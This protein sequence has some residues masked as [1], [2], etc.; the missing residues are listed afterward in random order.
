MSS[1]PVQTP[2]RGLQVLK[3]ALFFLAGLMLALGLFFS[4]SLITGAHAV[5]GNFLLPFEFLNQAISNLIGPMITSFLINLGVI[6]LALSIVI[7]ALLFAIGLLIGHILAL[8][9]RIARLERG[10]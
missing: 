1:T 9:G 10:E 5:V 3:V 7:S 4:I 8:E 6:F 2:S